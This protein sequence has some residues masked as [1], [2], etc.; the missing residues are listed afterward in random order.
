MKVLWTPEALQ[1]RLDI[2]EY[3]A[4]DN[5]IAATR[6]DK[7]FSDAAAKLADHPN[8]KRWMTE[9]VEQLA[10]W[11]KTFVGPGFTLTPPAH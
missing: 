1:D 11:K 3:I 9:Q 7:L 8:L 5:P 2:W 10:C 6:M 4:T